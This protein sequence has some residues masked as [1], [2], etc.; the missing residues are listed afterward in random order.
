MTEVNGQSSQRMHLSDYHNDN[1]GV[2]GVSQLV[3]IHWQLLFIFKI[4]IF[5][6]K[7]NHIS[8]GQKQ[9]EHCQCHLQPYSALRWKNPFLRCSALIPSRVVMES[10]ILTAERLEQYLATPHLYGFPIAPRRHLWSSSSRPWAN[11]PWDGLSRYQFDGSFPAPLTS[12][13]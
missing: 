10:P 4:I 8:C 3:S 7:S 11:C 5:N 1:L 9:N 6:I 13:R 2:M 12:V